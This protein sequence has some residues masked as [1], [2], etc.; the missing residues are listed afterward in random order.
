MQIQPTDKIAS[1]LIIATDK[2]L[3]LNS[4]NDEVITNLTK[5]VRSHVDEIHHLGML[6]PSSQN[7]HL[8]CL[9][10]L[11]HIAKIASSRVLIHTR[12]GHKI[13]YSPL[14][15]YWYTLDPTKQCIFENLDHYQIEKAIFDKCRDTNNIPLFNSSTRAYSQ[16]VHEVRTFEAE[17][18]RRAAGS[19]NLGSL[20][21]GSLGPFSVTMGM[22]LLSLF[23]GK[24]T[25]GFQGTSYAAINKLLNGVN[26]LCNGAAVA[27]AISFATPLARAGVGVVMERASNPN[28][29]SSIESF[30]PGK[31]SLTRAFATSEVYILTK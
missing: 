29:N 27:T 24:I 7:S 30:R 10:L 19:L 3:R 11:I 1:Y 16:F 12:L 2:E 25:T 13:S 31:D 8:I 17:V 15:G 28:L 5:R 6:N 9:N 4:M 26:S 20:F 18:Q 14:S 21:R 23:L 22:S